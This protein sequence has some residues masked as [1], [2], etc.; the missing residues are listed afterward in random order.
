[1]KAPRAVVSGVVLFFACQPITAQTP[2]H[3]VAWRVFSNR[4]GWS[5]SHPRN[6]HISS[7]EACTDPRDADVFAEFDSP[8]SEDSS[9][10]S[11]S[12]SP[13]VNKPLNLS[14]DKWFSKVEGDGSPFPNSLVREKRST[15]NGMPTLNIL[16][17][18]PDGMEI[19]ETYIVSRPDA[20]KIS[21]FCNRPGA[22]EECPTYPAYLR[23]LSSFET[24]K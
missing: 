17:R 10:G 5:I 8:R 19:E 14:L 9:R 22:I 6:W 12:V 1:M 13:L 21:F 7:C 18:D 20:F 24:K 16:Y 15:L 23:M 3:A 4:A 11:V 2:Q